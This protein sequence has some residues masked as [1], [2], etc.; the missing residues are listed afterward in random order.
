MTKKI[1]F[2]LPCV[3]YPLTAGG[4]QAFFNMVEYL[5]HRMS[6]SLLLSPEKK[7]ISYVE[8][9]KELWPNIVFYLFREEDAEPKTRCPKYYRWLKRMSESLTR[10]MQRQ[11]Y[12]FQRER[13]YKNMTLRNSYFKPFSKA[14][15]EYVSQV[16]RCGFDIVQVEFYPLITLGYLL[17]EDVETVFIHHELRYLRNKNEMECLARVTDEEKM[18]YHIAKDMEC[19]ALQQYKHVIVL[20]DIDRLLLTD[21]IGKKNNIYVSPAVVQMEEGCDRV[22]MPTT[23][24]L[25]FVGSESHY[26]N[27]DAVDWFCHEIAPCLRSQG[28]NFI[29][30]VIGIWEGRYVKSL[31]TVCPEMELVGYVENLREYLNGS[32]VLVPIRIGSG[33]RMKILDSIF[34]MAPFVTTP[35][36]VEG[37]DLRHDEECLIADGAA[38]FAAAIIRLGADKNLQFK[39][40]TQALDRLRKLYDPKEMLD[41]RLAVYNDILQK[42]KIV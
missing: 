31:R 29:F 23:T 1:L 5:R 37:L 30:Q 39:L 12:S 19:A 28:I 8:D 4:N 11:L 17:P 25:T 26:P 40:A 38:D 32:I 24:R 15:V 35:K 21:L 3:P 33:M 16:S 42:S 9:L 10:K 27:Q 6:V 36:G 14:Y 2:I 7:E 20:T 13:P 18:L 22:V 41:R 34:S